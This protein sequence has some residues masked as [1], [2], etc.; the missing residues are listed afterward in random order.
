MVNGACGRG[1]G[2][3]STAAPPTA[4]S[5]TGAELRLT[6]QQISEL[7]EAFQLFDKDGDGHVT[8]KELMIVLQTLGQ[9]PTVETVQES[10]LNPCSTIEYV[11]DTAQQ[12]QTCFLLS[13]SINKELCLGQGPSETAWKRTA[14]YDA[15]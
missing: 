6:E 4:V 11:R 3:S 2:G 8:S 5:S 12:Q 9:D 13:P 15:S 10:C 7:R 14:Q 1:V